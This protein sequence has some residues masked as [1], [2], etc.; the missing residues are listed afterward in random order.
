MPRTGNEACACECACLRVDVGEWGSLCAHVRVREC[1]IL[2]I[3]CQKQMMKR[4]QVVHASVH[5]RFAGK[6]ILVRIVCAS[7]ACRFASVS[8]V[9]GASSMCR[10]RESSCAVRAC[11]LALE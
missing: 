5:I 2:F 6:S 11:V 9:V 1:V 4:A 8:C 10:S 3:R 7:C